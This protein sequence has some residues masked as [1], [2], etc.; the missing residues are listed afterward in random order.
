MKG[1]PCPLAGAIL[2]GGRSSRMGRPKE[3]VLLA[4]GRPM[5]EH[6]AGALAPLVPRIAILGDSGGWPVPEG[7]IQLRDHFPGAG[8]LAGIDALLQSG[9]A[10]RYLVVSCDQPLLRAETLRRL[11]AAS[12]ASA[13]FFRARSG[14][15]LDPL[16]VLLPA[17]L[18]ADVRRALESA[19]GRPPGLRALL[20]PQAQ[21]I[22]L[23]DGEVPLLRSMNTPADL[24]AA[25]LLGPKSTPS[26][27]G[28]PPPREC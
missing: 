12:G 6:V 17:S 13:A 20:R 1:E 10:V 11:L 4:D 28:D 3:G 18:A 9:I 21:W 27:P 19:A 7:M 5:I 2:A 15:E 8:P 25:G 16:P 14:E 24:E 26:T 22:P 23:P